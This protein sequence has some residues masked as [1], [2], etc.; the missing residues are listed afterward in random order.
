MDES[1][2]PTIQDKVDLSRIFVPSD[3]K[4]HRHDP[5]Y[6]P[7][8]HTIEDTRHY[9]QDVCVM[10]Q[11][12]STK[13][14]DMFD[15]SDNIEPTVNRFALIDHNNCI[16]LLGFEQSNEIQ[17][18]ILGGSR[19]FEITL[20]DR[21]KN[22][23]M[24]IKSGLDCCLYNFDFF[25]CKSATVS[26]RGQVIGCVKQ[27]CSLMSKNYKLQDENSKT[28]LHIRG[29]V[30]PSL[31]LCKPQ[32]EFYI[33]DYRGKRQGRIYKN[34]SSLVETK[35]DEDFCIEL[36]TEEKPDT[37]ALALASMILIDIRYFDTMSRC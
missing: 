6:P 14:L 23:V 13:D 12:R 21:Y 22:Q 11:S 2:N 31:R 15:L 19:S 20:V 28:S 16:S 35:A 5:N 24:S 26:L 9:F 29:P 30:L 1:G 3:R 32:M 25:G 33:N 4:L 10:R 7:K 17:R 8:L 34:W 27:K 18:R 36:P 37:K